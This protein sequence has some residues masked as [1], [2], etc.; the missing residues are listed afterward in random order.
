MYSSTLSLTWPLNGVG[1]KR[2]SLAL[3]PPRKDT[4]YLFY[5]RLGGHQGRSGLGLRTFKPI[6]SRY[7]DEAISAPPIYRINII[8]FIKTSA[9]NC[10]LS[11]YHKISEKT[12]FCVQFL[13]M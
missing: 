2:N 5:R 7:T 4:R 6:T 3:L 13:C 11:K 12:S 8:I 10:E 1:V 9:T